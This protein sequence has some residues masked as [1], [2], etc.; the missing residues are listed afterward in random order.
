MIKTAR[1]QG[2]TGWWIALSIC[3]SLV[4]LLAVAITE[5]FL[6]GVGIWGVN[7]PVAWGF[8][9]IN[10]VWWIGIGHAGTF[11]SAFLYLMRQEWRTSISRF[12][13]TM[14]LMAVCCAGIYPLLHL[15]RPWFFY[16]LVPYPTTLSLWPQFRS[17]LVWDVMAVSSYLIVSL[18][19]WYF[20]L[21]P[22]LA[23][24]RDAAT[25][26]FARRAYGIFA[27]GWRGGSR[28]WRWYKGAYL[29]FAGIAAP[30]VVSV[31]SIVGMDFAYASVPGWHSA[32]FPPY[33]VA[34][35]IFS[36]FAMV[37]TLGIMLRRVL[38]LEKEITLHHLDMCA[39]F[40]LTTALMV[41]YGYVMEAFMPY[42]TQEPFDLQMI[43]NRFF[44]PYAAISWFMIFANV[45]APQALWSSRVRTSPLILFGLSLLFQAGMWV[46]RFVIVVTSLNR[47]FLSSSWHMF[48]P[49]FWDWAT[50]AG[51]IG[52]FGTLGLLAARFLPMLAITEL[53]EEAAQ[54]EPAA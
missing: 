13:E 29:L 49:T 20:G 41:A 4:G 22:D 45:V 51:T 35:A 8:A 15:G 39:R 24:E 11:I 1:F 31:H 47:D 10:F 21:V 37:L 2:G 17:P 34:G 42:F 33:F 25:T 43:H 30:L 53:R 23:V 5:L 46:E 32:I 16:W 9:I 7:V 27:L 38:H 14:T 28:H 50:F 44:G 26:T 54:K 52:L 3:L 40:T 48:Y 36:G 12:A 6:K 19:F 18:L